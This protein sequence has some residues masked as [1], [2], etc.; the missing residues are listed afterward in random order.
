MK[1]TVIVTVDSLRA[2]HCSG[3]GYNRETT[4]FIG[5]LDA[6]VFERAYANAPYTP[7]SVPSFLTGTLPLSDGHAAFR[8]DCTLP[9]YLAETQYTT[10]AVFNNAQI[11]RFGLHESFDKVHDLTGTASEDSIDSKIE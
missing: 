2:D 11:S 9:E 10:A 3:Y 4:P 7:A 6:H 5:S 1:N 8:D